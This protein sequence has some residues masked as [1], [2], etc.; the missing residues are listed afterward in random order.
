MSDTNKHNGLINRAAV[1]SKLIEHAQDT[2]YY[3]KQFDP[4]VSGAT[5]DK[6]EALVGAAIRDIVQ[7]LPSKGQT[8]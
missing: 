2:R 1:K 8:I 3:W 6:I 7:K 5:L 4:R